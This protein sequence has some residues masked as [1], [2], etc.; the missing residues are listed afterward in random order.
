MPDQH[1]GG[2]GACL[3]HGLHCKAAG[4]VRLPTTACTLSKRGPWM[5]RPHPSCCGRWRAKTASRGLRR[6]RHR[7][8]V[9][10]CQQTKDTIKAR[11]SIS[12][13]ERSR[14]VGGLMLVE[15]SQV[16]PRSGPAIARD[17]DATCCPVNSPQ[18]TSNLLGQTPMAPNWLGCLKTVAQPASFADMHCAGPE[19]TCAQHSTRCRFF[20][21]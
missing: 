16:V 13:S 8:G 11:A 7:H 15:H 5:H 12:V 19:H 21:A 17:Q 2:K 3:H 6:H 10:K 9:R 18:G 14:R 20:L 4:L 1:R